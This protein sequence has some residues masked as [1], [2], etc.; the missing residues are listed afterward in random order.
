M[1]ETCA[2][3]SPVIISLVL[4]TAF[5]IHMCAMHCLDPGRSLGQVKVPPAMHKAFSGGGSI[6]SILHLILET[7]NGKIK[8]AGAMSLHFE[9]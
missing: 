8:C 7:K 6:C 9:K 3:K 5:V 1:N 4:W 2:K